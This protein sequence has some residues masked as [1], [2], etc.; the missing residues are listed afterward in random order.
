M[1]AV[2]ACHAGLLFVQLMLV[3]SAEAALLWQLVDVSRGMAL[4]VTMM[5][6]TPRLF[7]AAVYVIGIPWLLAAVAKSIGGG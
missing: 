2:L 6:M 4:I 1:A 7:Y 5:S 3:A